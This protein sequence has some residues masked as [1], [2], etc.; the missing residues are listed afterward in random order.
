MLFYVDP[1]G[2]LTKSATAKKKFVGNEAWVD[3]IR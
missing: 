2:A 1:K 3:Q